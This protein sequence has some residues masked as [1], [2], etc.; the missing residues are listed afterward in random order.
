MKKYI[1]LSLAMFAFSAFAFCDAQQAMEAP[2]FHLLNFPKKVTLPAGTLILLETTEKSDASTMT[3]GQLL[4]FKVKTDVIVNGR[5]L[6]SS[7]AMATG[8]IKAV[9]KPTYNDPGTVTIDVLYVQSVDGQQIS[10]NGTEQTFKSK[11]AGAPAAIESGASLIAQV[12]ND[13]KVK[14]E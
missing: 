1:V 2:T 10:T 3:K 7:G 13:T 9:G 14:A 8:R 5:T 6:I 12:T 11:Y 4:H